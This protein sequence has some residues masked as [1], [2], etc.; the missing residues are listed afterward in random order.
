LH[1]GRAETKNTGKNELCVGS[2]ELEDGGRKKKGKDRN[3]N[4]GF[5]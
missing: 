4:K 5:L 1:K 2:W 3:K